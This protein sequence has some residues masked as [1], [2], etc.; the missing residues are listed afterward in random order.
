MVDLYLKHVR[1]LSNPHLLLY[2]NNFYTLLQ[3]HR[4]VLHGNLLNNIKSK[5]VIL[6][7]RICFKI[8]IYLL[9]TPLIIVCKF[10]KNRTSGLALLAV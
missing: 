1:L 7:Q 4:R 8:G 2:E 6:S 10:H 9:Y 5:D 3:D